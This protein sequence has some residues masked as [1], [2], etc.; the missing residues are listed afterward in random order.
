MVFIQQF[1]TE[2]RKKEGRKKREK[3]KDVKTSIK[4]PAFT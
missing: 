1:L 4:T 2:R 3:E